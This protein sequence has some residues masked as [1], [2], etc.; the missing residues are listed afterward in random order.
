MRLTPLVQGLEFRGKGIV[1][2]SRGRSGEVVAFAQTEHERLVAALKASRSGT[3]RWNIADDIVEWDEA[4][5]RVYGIDPAKAPRTAREF[6]AL[7]HPD[8]REEAWANI[9]ACIRTGTD[10]DY[11][12]RVVVGDQVRWIYDRSGLQRN[13]DGSPAFLLGACLDVT[14]RRRVADERDAALAKQTLLLKE[15]NHRVKNHLSMIVSLLRLKGSRQ[16]DAGAKQD[17]ERSIERVN[18]IAYLHD[19][20]YRTDRVDRVDA[21]AYI[22]EICAN[23]RQSI[24]ADSEIAISTELQPFDLHVDQAIPIGLIVNELITNA[25]KYAFA[26][27]QRG[28]IL[29]RFHVLGDR[30]TLTISDNGRGMPADEPDGVGMRLI[31]G[32]AEQ[33]NAKL[34]V[35]SRNGVTCSLTF[36]VRDG[37]AE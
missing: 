15:L 6:V 23:L 30:A 16:T 3:W 19:R 37:K 13:P 4:L 35:V 29:V 12:F 1:Q 26:P 10:A 25:I 32:L 31:R 27:G 14:E 22:G 33:V 34:R 21:Q 11:T 17:F 18:T 28:T 5:C 36:Q 24:L 8:D 9:E 20:L 2:K 7:I